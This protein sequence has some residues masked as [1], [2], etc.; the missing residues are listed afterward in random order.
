[1]SADT[2]EP[3]NTGEQYSIWKQIQLCKYR[4]VA[5]IKVST[6]ENKVELLSMN[7]GHWSSVCDDNIGNSGNHC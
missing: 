5:M 3:K 7:S 6:Y 4:D 2:K 1:M